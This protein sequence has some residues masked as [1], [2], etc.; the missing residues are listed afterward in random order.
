[1]K[2]QSLFAFTAAV[3]VAFALYHPMILPAHMLLRLHGVANMNATCLHIHAAL[4]SEQQ[5]LLAWP[6]LIPLL[7]GLPFLCGGWSVTTRRGDSCFGAIQLLH[8][9]ET[10]VEQLTSHVIPSDMVLAPLSSAVSMILEVG[11]STPGN[12]ICPI[13]SS[14]YSP[15]VEELARQSIK[16]ILE[17]VEHISLAISRYV[18]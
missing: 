3:A 11:L 12:G 17:L 5:M 9:Q 7:S 16:G 1:M 13:P 14:N 10:L 8:D 6:C 2:Q 15:E 18:T 4:V